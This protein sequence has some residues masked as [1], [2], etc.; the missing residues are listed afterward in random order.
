MGVSYPGERLPA[1]PVEQ[2]NAAQKK[3][4]EALIS[5]SRRDARGP[6]IPMLRSPELLDR[7]QRLGEYL[8]FR[9]V[10]PRKLR[11]LAIL[12]TARHWQQ[13]YEWHAHLSH[14]LEAGLSEQSI[15]TLALDGDGSALPSDEATVLQFVR[16]LHRN[17][18]TGDA[19]YAQTEALLGEDGVVELCGIC[20]YYTLLAM[21]MN[22]ARTPAPPGASIPFGPP[23]VTD[24]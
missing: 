13:T 8:R 3:A 10:V 20:G 24:P 2:Q 12:A 7:A 9:S 1:I 4:I 14:G 22:V 11:E 5:G 16:Q 21:V 19:V 17:H 6:F 15:D 18:A 23:Q